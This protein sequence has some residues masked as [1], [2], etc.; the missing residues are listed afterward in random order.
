MWPPS[1]THWCLRTDAH[2]DQTLFALC[3][4]SPLLGDDDDNVG[5]D[6]HSDPTGVHTFEWGHTVYPVDTTENPS[7]SSTHTLRK[8]NTGA[9]A[10][11]RS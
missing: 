4:A 8:Q 11:C 3:I 9:F 2:V 7:S 10:A 1:D 5:D 6:A